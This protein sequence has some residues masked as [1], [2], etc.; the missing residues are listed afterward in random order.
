[1]NANKHVKSYSTSLAVRDKPIKTTKHY[2]TPTRMSA[3]VQTDD[4][5]YW[6]IQEA[7]RIMSPC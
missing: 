5:Q 6:P 1:M 4:T 3:I 2:F 7:T